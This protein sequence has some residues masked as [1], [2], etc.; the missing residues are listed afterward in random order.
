MSAMF[1]PQTNSKDIEPGGGQVYHLT[2]PFLTNFLCWLLSH[3]CEK[4]SSKIN[5]RKDLFGLRLRNIC[6]HYREGMVGV[7]GL[8][9]CYD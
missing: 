4:L 9:L 3:W 2:V 7:C 1:L 5:L 8:W 6:N